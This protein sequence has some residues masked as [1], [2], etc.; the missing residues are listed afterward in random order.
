MYAQIIT[1]HGVM[2]RQSL[3]C[4]RVNVLKRKKKRLHELTKIPPKSHKI[5]VNVQI[6]EIVQNDPP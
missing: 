6:L 3:H 4:S 1:I 5:I 2:I